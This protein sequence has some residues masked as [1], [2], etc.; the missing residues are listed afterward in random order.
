MVAAPDIDSNDAFAVLGLDP[1]GEEIDKKVIKMAFRKLAKK[2]HPDAITNTESSEYEKKWASEQFAKIS[3]AYEALLGQLHETGSVQPTHNNYQGGPYRNMRRPSSKRRKS[4]YPDNFSAQYGPASSFYSSASTSQTGPEGFWVGAKD[5]FSNPKYHYDPNDPNFKSGPQRNP[6]GEYWKNN[7]KTNFG[8]GKNSGERW[9]DSTS[10]SPNDYGA[11]GDAFGGH[12]VGAKR[13]LDPRHSYGHNQDSDTLDI[14]VNETVFTDFYSGEEAAKGYEYKP[15]AYPKR[16][17]SSPVETMF[18]DFTKQVN[19]EAYKHKRFYNSPFMGGTQGVVEGEET[20]FNDFYS[21][22]PEVVIATLEDAPEDAVEDT[23]PNVTATSV[24]ESKS[25]LEDFL[26]GAFNDDTDESSEKSIPVKGGISG[27]YTGTGFSGGAV[28]NQAGQVNGGTVNIGKTV[29]DDAAKKTAATTEPISGGFSGGTTKESSSTQEAPV[30]PGT[31]A[32]KAVNSAPK[33]A[34]PA[35]AFT[36]TSVFSSVATGTVNGAAVEGAAKV[37]GTTGTSVP[38]S[39]LF[40]VANGNINGAAA[41]GA[42]KPKAVPIG[43]F[44][45]KPVNAYAGSAASNGA[46]RGVTSTPPGVNT[47]GASNTR[48]ASTKYNTPRSSAAKSEA[49][50]GPASQTVCPPAEKANGAANG[51]NSNAV[52]ESPSSHVTATAGVSVG[53]GTGISSQG[54]VINKKYEGPETVINDFY[55]GKGGQG[56]DAS[57]FEPLTPSFP[58]KGGGVFREL[59]DLLKGDSNSGLSTITRQVDDADLS[60][61]LQTGGVDEIGSEMLDT[62][63]VVKQLASKLE[64]LESEILDILA[65]LDMN[66]KYANKIALEQ[67]EAECIARR[68]VVGKF[69]PKAQE[70][71]LALQ[72][73]YKELMAG[74]QPQNGIPTRQNTV[75][76]ATAPNVPF[77][78]AHRTHAES[79]DVLRLQQQQEEAANELRLQEEELARLEKV[80]ARIRRQEAAA[81]RK[82]RLRS[83]Q[84]DITWIATDRDCGG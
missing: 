1:Y 20:V 28:T 50:G 76:H 31:V 25:S 11:C 55:T 15:R 41:N 73:R 61:L 63:L 54:P 48:T 38:P 65:E 70:R 59:V 69:L 79:I 57:L 75:F 56:E 36:A 3:G 24:P 16:D 14:N 7:V 74:S 26:T 78:P 2:Y 9:Y 35:H 77:S 83:M 47:V 6:F 32:N 27:N 64:D 60:A 58:N 13:D 4:A 8:D 23:S 44:N 71:M 12:W 82:E 51:A 52:F 53:A 40:S 22:D 81:K 17:L 84:P 33:P 30:A 46:K 42:A 37:D 72:I 62:Q 39:V 18:N 66:T 68:D 43:T 80:A 21:G 67:L 45:G 49:I 5:T 29:V 10:Y 34:D 19:T